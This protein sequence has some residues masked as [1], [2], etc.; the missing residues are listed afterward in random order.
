MCCIFDWNLIHL[1]KIMDAFTQL[2]HTLILQSYQFQTF[3]L[4]KC[5]KII[6]EMMELVAK[7]VYCLQEVSIGP[8]SVVS[9]SWTREWLEFANMPEFLCPSLSE[10]F[11]MC[12]KNSGFL[13]FWL[14][15]SSRD[16]IVTSIVYTMRIISIPFKY[17]LKEWSQRIFP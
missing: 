10:F 2:I 8:N 5:N 17:L 7:N 4:K 11:L 15:R 14:R 16:T 12:P 3:Q 6:H 13:R 1:T 9:E